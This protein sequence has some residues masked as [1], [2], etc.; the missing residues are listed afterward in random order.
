MNHYDECVSYNWIVQVNDLSHIC[1]S[2]RVSWWKMHT[3]ER[4]GLSILKSESLELQQI[5]QRN[6]IDRDPNN[7]AQFSQLAKNPTF[8]PTTSM[9]ESTHL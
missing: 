4:V 2:T 6:I 1:L 3:K 9:G 7:V 5:L 8:P